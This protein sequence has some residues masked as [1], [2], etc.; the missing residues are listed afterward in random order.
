MNAKDVKRVNTM[1]KLANDL[2]NGPPSL[3][4]VVTNVDVIEALIG[5]LGNV[6]IEREPTEL[7]ALVKRDSE[8]HCAPCGGACEATYGH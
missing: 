6:L 8:Q 4:P 5:D 3:N 1:I 7:V 2:M